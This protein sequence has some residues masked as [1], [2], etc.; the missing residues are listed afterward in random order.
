MATNIIQISRLSVRLKEEKRAGDPFAQLATIEE[1]IF[2]EP[3]NANWKIE[4]AFVFL[5]VGKADRTVELLQDCYDQGFRNTGLVLN[6][7]HAYSAIG[8][9]DQAAFYYNKLVWSDDPAAKSAG[10]WSLT[11]LKGYEFS[12]DQIKAMEHHVSELKAGDWHR[13]LTQFALGN[14]YDRMHKVSEAFSLLKV[15]NNQVAHIRPYDT[16]GY[17]QFA[18]SIKGVRKLPSGKYSFDHPV[19]IFIV[20]MP[21]SGS[22]LV[23]QILASNSHVDATTEL[24]Y[25]EKL[26][27][28]M[29]LSGGFS[30]ILQNSSPDFL[31]NSAG[32]YM[33]RVK[34]FLQGSPKAFTDKWPNNFWYIGLIKMLFPNAKIIN[35]LRDPMDN[36]IG[37]YKQY[38]SQGNEH[39]FKLTSILAYWKVYLDVIDHWNRLFPGQIMH[40][41]Y[42]DLVQNPESQI[43]KLFEYC[44]LDF[45]DQSLKF[46]EIDR[47]IMTPSGG[48]VRQPIYTTSLGSAA[49]Y[50]SQLKHFMSE[51]NELRGRVERIF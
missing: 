10:Y 45:E 7:G 25:I 40:V 12:E 23:E 20:G 21:R 44:E 2:L 43:R 27:R 6:L 39:S 37:V 13:Y 50:S 15:A 30:R 35:T 8:K 14:A 38:F 5:D 26:A 16:D 28:K 22:T 3:D 49:K 34:P 48:Q 4:Q 46:Y 42:T 41:R 32:D 29:D 1:L 36:A 47:V 24:P 33:E 18:N 19:P 11:D 17:V 31:A 9:M 51:F